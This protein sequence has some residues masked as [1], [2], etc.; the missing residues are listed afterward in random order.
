MI[1]PLNCS[2][3]WEINNLIFQKSSS[4]G[5]NGEDESIAPMKNEK[6]YFSTIFPSLESIM[7]NR[8][9]FTKL[10][11]HLVIALLLFHAV[12]WWLRRWWKILKR[13]PHKI[14][15]NFFMALSFELVGKERKPK[16]TYAGGWL[17]YK[18]Q[19]SCFS[20]CFLALSTGGAGELRKSSS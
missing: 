10:F 11:D 6:L 2:L 3:N 7:Q 19:F 13:K 9:I 16:T 5:E 4:M 20:C 15:I 14:V 18:L 1:F 8:L 17:T 12:S